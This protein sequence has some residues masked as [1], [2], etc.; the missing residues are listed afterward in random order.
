[1]LDQPDF[2]QMYFVKFSS[3]MSMQIFNLTFV[4]SLRLVGLSMIWAGQ[5]S[6]SEY[7]GK[8]EKG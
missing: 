3:T 7:L 8:I 1:M 6:W 2:K 5:H 4:S